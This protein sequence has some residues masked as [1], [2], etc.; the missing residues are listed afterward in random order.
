MDTRA[1]S[2]ELWEFP[3]SQSVQMIPHLF[4]PMLAE[5][6]CSLHVCR[7]FKESQEVLDN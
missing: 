1:R 6:H 5:N 2:G 7:L 4:V 3:R